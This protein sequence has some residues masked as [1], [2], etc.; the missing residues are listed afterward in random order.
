[1]SEERGIANSVSLGPIRF[2]SNLVNPGGFEPPPDSNPKRKIL[3]VG[4]TG[5]ES[6][7]ARDSGLVFVK[8]KIGTSGGAGYLL[9]PIGLLPCGC[10]QLKQTAIRV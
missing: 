1:M 4:E 9:F 5:G 6:L 10:S 8:D 3:R 2:N 7:L